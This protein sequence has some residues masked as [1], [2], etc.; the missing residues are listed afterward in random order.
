MNGSKAKQVRKKAHAL[1]FDWLHTLVSPEEA[2]D[3]TKQ[4]YLDFFPTLEKYVYLTNKLTLSSYTER[5]FIQNIKKQ[6]AN[7]ELKNITLQDVL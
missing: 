5:W 1:M 3:I 2:K 6:L 7:K 4:N